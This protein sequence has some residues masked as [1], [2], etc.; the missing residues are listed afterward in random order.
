MRGNTNLVHLLHANSRQTLEDVEMTNNFACDVTMT[1]KIY[2]FIYDEREHVHI[3][4]TLQ[5]LRHLHC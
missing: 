3:S 1:A 5:A 2:K 4:M